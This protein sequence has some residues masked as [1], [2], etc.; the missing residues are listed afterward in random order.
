MNTD[1]YRFKVGK[2]ECIAVSDGTHTYAPPGFPPPG[3][4][5]FDNAPGE[6]LEQALREHNLQQDKWSEWTSPYICL[7]VN[8]GERLVLVD[9]GADGLPQ[10]LED[11]STT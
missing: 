4:L 11:F 3:I 5:L 2:I 7:V 1:N 8:T 9:T 10:I 6:S